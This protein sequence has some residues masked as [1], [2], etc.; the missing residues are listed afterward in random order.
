[1]SLE[2]RFYSARK[3]CEIEQDILAELSANEDVADQRL[4][5]ITVDQGVVHLTRFAASYAQKRAIVRA[6]GRI[7]GVRE[8]RD[9]L[10]VRPAEDD[11]RE[12]RRIERA[13]RRALEWDVRVPN[14][15]RAEVTD[16]VVRLHGV[17]VQRFSQREAAEEAVRNLIGVRD[18][19]N[20][21]KVIPVP[22]P[23]DLEGHVA[24]AIR[25]RFG[26]ECRDISITAAG[27]VVTLNGEVSTFALLDDIERVVRAVPGVTHIDN[28]L[29]VA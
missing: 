27:G 22:P 2:D 29:L 25:R 15:V 21:I 6:A 18:I 28:Q 24:A 9:Y 16:G 10:D 14:G 11:L 3:D 20:E 17:A 5:G 7:L 4:I 12:D 1:M 13:A 26:S 23:A 8:V 19:V